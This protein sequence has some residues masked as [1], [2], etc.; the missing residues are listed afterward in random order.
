MAFV[1]HILSWLS[2]EGTA[3]I[4]E[5]PGVLYR[6]GAEQKIR[7]YL[8]K[9]NYVDTIIQL[10]PN[11][12]FGETIA[13][14][15]IVLKKNKSDNRVLF[16]DASQEFEHEGNKNRLSDANIEKIYTIHINKEEIPHFSS[17]VTIGDIAE[18]KY[19]LSVSTYVEPEDTTVEIDINELNDRIAKIVA[20]ENELRAKIDDII[21]ELEARQQQY[22]YYRNKLLT[23]E[24][25]TA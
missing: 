17:I 15:I 5:F 11:M 3:A 14:C 7:E 9:N 22:E 20:H 10:A 12:F 19:N 25:A 4:V 24:R 21:A 16:I 18:K 6:G 8:V 23:F 2:T 13:T 1:M